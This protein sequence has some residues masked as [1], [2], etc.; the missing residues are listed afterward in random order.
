[1][2]DLAKNS[3]ETDP[4]DGLS[5]E[6]PLRKWTATA[7]RYRQEGYLAPDTFRQICLNETIHEALP[8]RPYYDWSKSVFDRAAALVLI[9]L[10]A[11][12]LICA[13]AAVLLLEGRPIFYTQTRSGRY[14][15]PFKII[16]FR[17]MIPSAERVHHFM[18]NEAH[19]GLFKDSNDQRITRVGRFLRR[20]SIDELPQL[21][22]VLLGDMSLVG[23]RPL[24]LPDSATVPPELLVRFGVK[25]G[26]TGY[27]QVHARSEPNGQVKLAMDAIYVRERGWRQD[28]KLIALTIPRVLSGRGAF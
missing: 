6:D 3:R 21:F 17:T 18:V 16:K 8:A 25:P 7:E 5:V 22:N 2:I 19:G 13:M 4:I 28:L 20:S 10:L 15:A 12:V 26:I 23:P 9:V 14:F 1:M 24:P 27:W 11:P